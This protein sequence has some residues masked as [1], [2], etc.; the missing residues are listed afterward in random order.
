MSI[1]YRKVQN[2]I[3]NSNGFQKWYGKAVILSTVS[4][5]DLAEEL[6]HST[7]VTRADILAVLAELTVA[8]HNHL[9]NSHKVVI[10]GLGTF[11]PGLICKSADDE[12]SFNASNIKGYRIVYRP[13]CKYTVTGVNTNGNR[14]GFFTKSLLQGASAEL[15][16]EAKKNKSTT[17]TE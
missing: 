14:T 12:K 15:M 16:P 5:K 8:M 1:R 9:L 6:S 2:K 4:T 7:T 11:R 10:D 13:E 3:E 17:P